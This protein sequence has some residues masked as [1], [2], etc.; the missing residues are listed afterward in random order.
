LFP[1]SERDNADGIF[2]HVPAFYFRAEFGSVFLEER[3][4][5]FKDLMAEKGREVEPEKI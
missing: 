3:V 2:K 4:G 5:Q 1:C